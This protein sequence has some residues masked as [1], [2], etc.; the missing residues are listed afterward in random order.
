MFN[1]S[2]KSTTGKSTIAE[3]AASLYATPETS[4]Y[5][6][7]R[8]FNATKNFIF[9]LSEG[10]H[11]LPII[12][13]D[14]NANSKEHDKADIIYKFALG[15]S[16]GRCAS[17]GTPGQ[18]HNGW[19]GVVIVT[20][21]SP[22]LD[23]QKVSQGANVRCITLD[24]ISW[25]QSAAHSDAIK[26]GVREDYGF[27]AELFANYL[28]TIDIHKILEIHENNSKTINSKM[29]KRDSLSARIASK[30][31]IVSTTAELLKGFDETMKIEPFEIIDMLVAAEQSSFDDRSLADTTLE[32]FV[33]FYSI[34]R[35]R[36][37]ICQKHK[38]GSD[39]LDVNKQP[40]SPIGY[41]THYKDYSY[42]ELGILNSE[43]DKF[44]QSHQITERLTILKEWKSR[45]LIDGDKDRYTKK[46]NRCDV[47][48]RAIVFN[49]SKI[50]ELY[51]FSENYVNYNN[52]ED[53]NLYCSEEVYYG[54]ED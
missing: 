17:G 24:S 52:F 53:P 27:I 54:S 13:D 30:L 31:A 37:A 45:G 38:K 33:E 25:T 34:N 50:Y 4:N 32:L 23:G 36:F 46:V 7:V 51:P 43:F 8:T 3:L 20:S 11:G 5:G 10:R 6:L 35:A 21:E 12:L 9:A 14:A 22:I 26:H 42:P 2:G 16:R 49:L 1:V 47:I 28:K 29:I 15:E 39:F 40:A 41:I 44:L 19:S 18:R 48:G